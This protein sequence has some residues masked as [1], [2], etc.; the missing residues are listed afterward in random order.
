VFQVPNFTQVM[1][2]VSPSRQGMAGGLAFMV[3]TLGIVVGVQSTAMLFAARAASQ[4]FVE[5]FG[6]AFV[7]AA[8]VCGL[9]A[10]AALAPAPGRTTRP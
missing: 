9:A 4:G 7:V 6:L 1:R 3:R 2:S 5:G 10:L 8:A